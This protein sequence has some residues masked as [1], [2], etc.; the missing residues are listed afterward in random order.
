MDP[1]GK[2]VNKSV[3]SFAFHQLLK[4]IGTFGAWYVF[5][6]PKGKWQMANPLGRNWRVV[7]V[8]L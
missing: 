7:A 1:L 6:L 2:G 3:S 5:D 8:T 4:P